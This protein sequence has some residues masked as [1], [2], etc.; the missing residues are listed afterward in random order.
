L[1]GWTSSGSFYVGGNATS[2]G[3]SAIVTVTNSGS[4]NI[5]GTLMLWNQGAMNIVG[6]SPV[7]A[8]SLVGNGTL[9][10]SST[11]VMTLT[12][13][14]NFAGS[15]AGS[16][17]VNILGGAL[18]LTGNS[19][20]FS[21]TVSIASGITVYNGNASG[22]TTGNGTMYLATGATLEGSGTMGSVVLATNSTLIVGLPSAP[23]T[24]TLG[25]LTSNGGQLSYQLGASTNSDV[26]AVTGSQL[27]FNSPTIVNVATSSGFGAQVYEL[28]SYASGTGIQNLSNLQLASTPSGYSVSIF[29]DIARQMIEL[30]VATGSSNITWTGTGS[31][32]QWTVNDPA[33]PG[34]WQNKGN[35]TPYVD[36]ASVTFGDSAVATT[37][38]IAGT[39]APAAVSF[40]NATAAYVITGGGAIG[41][42]TNVTINGGGNVTFDNLNTYTG[43]TLITAGT[44][45]VG[46]SSVISGGALVSGPLGAGSVYLS[47]AHFNGDGQT[48]ANPVALSDNITLV[49]S[50]ALT[51]SSTVGGNALTTAS[52][53]IL[54]GNT[55][56]TVSNQLTTIDESIVGNGR[57]LTLAAGRELCRLRRGPRSTCL[58]QPASP[59]API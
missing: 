50:G 43:S 59:R 55:T 18:T 30:V 5:G 12:A 4:V 26:I 57:S 58:V 13:G 34:N 35:P 27:A 38:T 44:V 9:T 45:T 25:S 24:L 39:V 22:S 28:F 32:V 20:A 36:G 29:N 53:V 8:Q 1:S 48:L 2:S 14:G 47:N 56:L 42:A 6:V 16:G 10:L 21:G 49:G 54:V 33:F 23:T 19:P 52:S 17:A 15:L 3:G 51:F 40:V 31:P 7:A 41:G 37:V 11:S 46:T